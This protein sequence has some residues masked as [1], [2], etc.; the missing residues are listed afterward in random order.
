MSE[1]KFEFPTEVV[2]LPSKGLVYPE[3]HPLKDGKIEDLLKTNDIITE[4]YKPI[5]G[6]QYKAFIT[7]LKDII[8]NKKCTLNIQLDVLESIIKIIDVI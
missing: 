2:D 5:K 6:S 4:K 1:N 7:E 8:N 3:G